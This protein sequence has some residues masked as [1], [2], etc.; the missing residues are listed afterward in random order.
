MFSIEKNID[1]KTKHNTNIK[2]N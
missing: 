2:W 1:S